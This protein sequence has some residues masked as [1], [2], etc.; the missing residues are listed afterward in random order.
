M[1]GQP[2]KKRG[3]SFEIGLVLAGAGAAGAYT[4][5]VLDFLIEALDCW[6]EARAGNMPGVP[7][8][9]VKL[10]V[11][12]G[13][14]AGAI[15]AALLSASL[16]RPFTPTH[17]GTDQVPNAFYDTWVNRADIRALLDTADLDG[18]TAPRALLNPACFETAA[19]AVLDAPGRSAGLSRSVVA[20]PLHVLL[21][22]TNLRGTPYSFEVS[23]EGGLA[24]LSDRVGLTRYADFFRFAVAGQNPNIPGAD[25]LNQAD[26]SDA[27]WHRMADVALASAALPLVLP[28]RLLRRPVGDYLNRTFP[29]PEATPAEAGGTLRCA[30]EQVI[31]PALT[32]GPDDLIEFAAV[33]GGALNNEPVELARKVLRQGAERNPR[34]GMEANRAVV[35]IDPF[36]GILE[37]AE[38]PAQVPDLL[39]VPGEI[40]GA[41]IGQ[42]RFRPE[43]LVLAGDPEIYSRFLVSPQRPGAQG[44]MERS[45][46]A[47]GGL[48]GLGGL[49]QRDFRLHDYLLGRQN[50]QLFLQEQFVLP[51]KNPVVSGWDEDADQRFGF[52]Y[53]SQRYRP[54]I[55]LLGS[56]ARPCSLPAWP[57]LDR[58]ALRGLRKPLRNRMKA[59][60]KPV[61]NELV[62]GP[63]ARLF[64]RWILA[65]QGARWTRSI[66]DMIEADFAHYA[67][68]TQK[69]RP[70]R[71]GHR[72][73]Q[74]ELSQGGRHGRAGPDPWLSGLR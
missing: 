22:V 65:L 64:V 60:V 31:P 48:S 66:L 33:D 53:G 5:G 42:A 10:R 21:T 30:S 71:D 11:V 68:M 36:P 52:L 13:A 26:T 37:G 2:A 45:P 28:S 12:T 40:L 19:H 35:L 32:G 43:E 46:L 29:I 73:H 25:F 39:N 54:I 38:G 24:T 16:T 61:S 55:P 15:N 8:H 27:D 50:C 67:A 14:S 58:R 74:T 23:G 63:L 57:E 59:L 18:G 56:A 62:D 34:S 51:A 7:H 17:P 44:A 6:A 72:S 47:G 41:L 49:F 69:G 20:D 3:K 1:N 9:D 4:A 70:P